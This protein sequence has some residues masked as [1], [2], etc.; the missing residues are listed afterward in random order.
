MVVAGALPGK[1]PQVDEESWLGHGHSNPDVEWILGEPWMFVRS[2][3]NLAQ[4][5]SLVLLGRVAQHRPVRRQ[6]LGR[7]TGRVSNPGQGD[8]PLV[9]A[10]TTL[11]LLRMTESSGGLLLLPA[12][13][14][15][16]QPS[17]TDLHY[18]LTCPNCGS[19]QDSTAC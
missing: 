1:S 6:S 13:R 4:S 9:E 18:P 19:V 8:A 3:L 11:L 5:F 14:I 12:A 10:R 7:N 17:P 16:R 15:H 2:G